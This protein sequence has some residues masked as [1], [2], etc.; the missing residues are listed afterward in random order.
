MK[1]H[2]VALLCAASLS[3]CAAPRPKVTINYA[4]MRARLDNGL[5]MVIIPDKTTSLVHVDV[6]YEVGSN[7]DPKGKA[8]IAHLV[9]HMMFQ[10]RM[11]GPDKPAT[12]D[13]L[14]QVTLGMNAWT[15]YDETHYFLIGAKE[16][17]DTLLKIEAFRMNAR[18]ET[19][20]PE[21]FDREREVVRNEIRQRTGTPEGA[22]Y[23]IVSKEVYPPG[24]PYHMMVGGDDTNLTSIKFEDVCWFMNNYYVPE[25]ATVIVTGNVDPNTVG[26]KIKEYFGAIPKRP[27]A[28]RV[29]VSPIELKYKRVEH[30][31]DIERTQVWALWKLPPRNSKDWDK[32]QAL[33]NMYG[34][35]AREVDEWE[36]A[37]DVNVTIWGGELAPTFAVIMELP[38]GGDADEALDVLWRKLKTAHWGWKNADF[39]KDGKA[40]L[41]MNFVES[42]ESLAAR[43]VLVANK[44]QYGGSDI[45]FDGGGEYLLEE[46]N[47]I[48]KL[49]PDGYS[50]FV[51][52]TLQKDKAVVVVFKPSKEGGRGDKRASLRFSTNAHD[53]QPEPLVDPAEARKPLPAPKS[54]SILSSAERY[55]LDNGM[56]VVLLPTKGLPIVHA[57]IVFDVGSAHEPVSQ[58]GLASV[59]AGYL[60][61]NRESNFTA[62]A[63]VAGFADQDNTTFYARGLNIYTEII[64]K[65]LERFVK[66]GEYDQE[67]IERYQKRIK[68]RYKSADFRRALTR[69]HEL[70]IALFGAEHPYAAKGTPTPESVD[71]IGYDAATAWRS[72]HYT[73]K[74]ATLIVVGAF[75]A[76]EVKDLISEN[77]DW[78]SG[79]HDTPAPAIPT[80]PVKSAFLGIVGEKD[81]QMGVTIAYPSPAGK[82][83]QFA[84]RLVLSEMLNMR[85]AAI[86][87]ELGSTYGTY[88]G[89]SGNL[90]PNYYQMGGNVDAERAGESLK[91]MRDRVDALRQGE[92][93]E[94]TF[95]LARRKV[96]KDLLND[97]SN[98]GELASRLASIAVFKLAPDYYDSLVK[99]VAAVS[100]AQ[101]KALLM[102][103]LD[104]KQEIILCTADRSTLDKAFKEA[105]L[106]N[107]RFIEPK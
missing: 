22:I 36:I 87:T 51:Q 47:R 24:H 73:A 81:P 99:Y 89:L 20:P 14:P 50:E 7:E 101:V 1:H 84:A 95:A 91:A 92:D 15:N 37:S 63:S 80:V 3:S 82:D 68:D 54:N 72:K 19:I 55:T 17:L 96:V 16:E 29:A 42:I 5:R 27:P 64:I 90:G 56:N 38:P 103:E 26:A 30:K 39:D 94:K 35:L 10:H 49:T 69:G 61:P 104:P 100:P 105:G 52:D 31:L 86:R 106:S 66:I 18:C 85:M 59:A 74:N 25:R 62:F 45:K 70:D 46:L 58:A 57:E 23:G 28:P 83:G 21:Q 34:R 93:F 79:S 9:E 75:D 71:N 44:I 40:F 48:D 41:K 6:R 8:G 98:T 43:A 76:G 32:V 107:A 13:L 65:G 11:L 102:A 97:S 4:E 77:F 2:L 33:F 88:A 60:R 78:D 67:S 53:K 12:F